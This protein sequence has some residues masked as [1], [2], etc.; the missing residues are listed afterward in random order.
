MLKNEGWAGDQLPLP[1]YYSG[2]TH[3]KYIEVASEQ[4]LGQPVV[5]QT[6]SV[7]SFH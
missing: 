5:L 2:F 1:K 6:R 4:L 3:K 7:I